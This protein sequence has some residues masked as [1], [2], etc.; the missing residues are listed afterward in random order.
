MSN[1]TQAQPALIFIPDISG[2]T[3]FVSETELNHSQHIITELLEAL[4]GANQT[5]LEIS[6]I[7]GDAILYYRFGEAPS[8][9]ELLDQVQK[10]FVHFHEHIARY[11]NRRIC[12]CG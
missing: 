12:Q 8:A 1:T 4:I 5:G 9:Q 7:E 2:F 6:E 10:M 3:Q 11:E